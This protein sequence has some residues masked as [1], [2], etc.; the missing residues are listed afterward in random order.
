M[1]G[2]ESEPKVGNCLPLSKIPLGTVI[3]NIELRAGRGGVLCRSAGTSATLMAREAD[4]AQ[5]SLPSGEIRRIPSACRATIG[6]TSNGDHSMIVLGKAGRKRWLGRRGADVPDLQRWSG[7]R[8]GRG[9]DGH[10]DGL[11]VREA[12]SRTRGRRPR[13]PRDRRREGP[14]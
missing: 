14:G 4:W 13:S 9:L 7:V 8:P 6:S 2:P 10:R 5:I 1:S 3:H 12:G 11:V